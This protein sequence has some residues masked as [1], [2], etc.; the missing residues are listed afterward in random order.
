MVEG[1]RP[2]NSL[3]GCTV[4]V[5]VS[6]ILLLTD[7]TGSA[8]GSSRLRCVQP[9]LYMPLFEVVLLVCVAVDAVRGLPAADVAATRA[10]LPA[11]GGALAGRLHNSST[12][13]SQLRRS[14][15]AALECVFK[16]HTG[17]HNSLRVQTAWAWGTQQH[18]RPAAVHCPCRLLGGLRMGQRQMRHS[19][20]SFNTTQ[21]T[22]ERPQGSRAPGSAFGGDRSSAGGSGSCDAC[23][24]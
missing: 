24:H 11:V 7:E 4:Q 6:A 13:L 21:H 20:V 14:V 12:C 3:K 5:A 9:N 1:W 22:L 2:C 19:S 23:V 8:C 15:V 16:Q 18:H 10:A 17:Q